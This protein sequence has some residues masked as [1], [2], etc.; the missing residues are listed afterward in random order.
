MIINLEKPVILYKSKKN[1]I[2]VK[3]LKDYYIWTYKDESVNFPYPILSYPYKDKNYV[4]G[5]L[6][7]IPVDESDYSAPTLKR[8]INY[9]S[10]T[11]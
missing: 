8:L 4:M 1:Y 3:F 11:N 5:L 2:Y 6:C 7:L 9:V 10:R